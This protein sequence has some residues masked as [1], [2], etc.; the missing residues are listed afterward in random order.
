MSLWKGP[1]QRE[2]ETTAEAGVWPSHKALPLAS[3]S[4]T[5]SKIQGSGFPLKD[6][7]SRQKGY[8]MSQG[9]HRCALSLEI[10]FR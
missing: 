5:P 6:K 9:L 10:Y 1:G 3:V 4:L 7:E 8:T 2:V